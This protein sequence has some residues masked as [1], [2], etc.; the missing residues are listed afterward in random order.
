MQHVQVQIWMHQVHEV[1]TQPHPSFNSTWA[2]ICT[3]ANTSFLKKEMKENWKFLLKEA[4]EKHRGHMLIL[5]LGKGL[6]FSSNIYFDLGYR[7]NCVPSFF[8]FFF[9]GWVCGIWKFLGPGSN[10]SHSCSLHHSCGSVG[11][12]TLCAGL[13][14]EPGPQ[15]WPK[16]LQRQRQVIN[17]LCHSGNSHAAH[18]FQLCAGHL[19]LHSL[20]P[21]K[22]CPERNS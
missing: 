11:S 21:C 8:F 2:N 14:I 9:N 4:K 20:Q 22:S 15:Q 17:P 16:S 12:L 6:L 7:M 18:L 13:G 5:Y 19:R 1:A 3:W 10:L